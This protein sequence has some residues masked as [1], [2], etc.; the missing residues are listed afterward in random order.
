MAGMTDMKRRY[1][2]SL[3]FRIVLTV[4]AGIL[5]LVTV[6]GIFHINLSK[7]VFIDN[8]SKSQDKIFSQID[9]EFYDFYEDIA[10]ILQNI[11]MNPMVVRYLQGTYSDHI[12]EW[13][14]IQGMSEAVERTELAGHHEF[15]LLLVGNNGRSYIHS[16]PDRLAVSEETIL[17]TEFAAKVEEHPRILESTYL[18]NGYTEITKDEPVI[19]F[20]KAI[21]ESESSRIEGIA[22]LTIKE[23]DFRKLYESFISPASN[24][25][26]FNRN[27]ELLSA[28]CRKDFLEQNQAEAKKILQEME[29]KN[30]KKMHRKL[31]NSVKAYQIQK[32]HN[33]SYKMLGVIDSNAAFDEEYHIWT[34]IL[35]T[36]AIGAA[37]VLV[38]FYLVRAQTRPLYRL[39]DTMR[40]VGK[41]KLDSYVEIQGTDEVRELSRTYNAMITELNCYIQRMLKMQEEK[42]Q[43]EIHAL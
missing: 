34:V 28:G 38:L 22:F 29:E 15:G 25:M 39:A 26:I 16:S 6:L 10:G 12:E 8:F 17:G 21:P 40:S 36:S 11:C 3:F 43:I 5:C 42:R 32:F 2:N 35:I 1:M 19:V 13:Q 23:E 18:G 30:V 14:T 4:I 33:T 31:R 7:R 20:A 24:I 27:N 41:G 9:T 37:V